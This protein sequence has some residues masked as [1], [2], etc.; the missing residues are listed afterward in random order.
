[1]NTDTRTVSLIGV[2]T[3][4][5]LLVLFGELPSSANWATV[6]SDSAHGPVSAILAIICMMLMRRR[7]WGST[8]T[9]WIAS[10]A[11][12]A[13]LGIA[14]ELVQSV[15]GRD[16]EVGDIVTDVLGAIVGTGAYVVI[17]HCRI[18]PVSRKMVTIGAATA[19]LATAVWSIPVVTV[20]GAYA[21]K[22]LRGPVLVDA[23][24]PFGTY[25]IRTYWLLAHTAPLPQQWQTPSQPAG[26]LLPLNTLTDRS[27]HWGFSVEEVKSDWRSY[28][29][30][31]VDVANPTPE[32][33]RLYMRIFD[34][35]DGLANNRGF[36]TTIDVPANTRKVSVVRTRDMSAGLGSQAINLNHIRGLVFGGSDA[37]ASN[38]AQAFYLI[39]MEL[40]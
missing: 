12:I 29:A 24:A 20:A 26:Y 2:A 9:Q 36:I 28:Q 35:N 22:H 37:G 32:P 33:L 7:A 4:L 25:F 14:I 27:Q 5:I 21:A 17:I 18:V 8:R 13:L 39:R 6:L 38:A 34:R 23:N 15:I 3:A 19:T 11:M 10:I 30:L 31:A 16:A 1:M 40:Q